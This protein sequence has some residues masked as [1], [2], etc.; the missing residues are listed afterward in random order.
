VSCDKLSVG[1]G[2]N[3]NMNNYTSGLFTTLS[4]RVQFEQSTDS[5]KRSDIAAGHDKAG[6]YYHECVYLC[7][8]KL[9]Y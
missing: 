7:L 6:L 3:R 1:I 8:E 5:V 4:D 2:A 9:V